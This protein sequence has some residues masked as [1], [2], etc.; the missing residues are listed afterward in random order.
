MRKILL[1]L[2][3]GLLFVLSSCSNE[4]K[5]V[6]YDNDYYNVEYSLN[7]KNLVLK[8]DYSISFIPIKK[9]KVIF[10]ISSI[11]YG[12]QAYIK[13]EHSLYE[14]P[15]YCL[16][17]YNYITQT[18]R[19]PPSLES[20][21][22]ELNFYVGGGTL[23]IEKITYMYEDDQ[24]IN[25]YYDNE[26]IFDSHL[27][28]SQMCPENTECAV[29]MAAKLGYDSCIVV[30]KETSDG[31]IVCIHDDTIN[32]TARDKNGNKLDCDL[33]VCELTLSNLLEYDFGI[34]K[35]K[36]WNNQKILTM[37][38]FLSLCKDYDISP[39][40]S[41]HPRLSNESWKYI[42]SLLIK[43]DLLQKTSIKAFDWTILKEAYDVFGNEISSYRGDNMPLTDLNKFL[44]SENINIDKKQI[45]IELEI[46]TLTK[47]KVDRYLDNGIR[48]YAFVLRSKTIPE[49]KIRDA[50][51]LGITG[52]V[53]DTYCQKGMLFLNF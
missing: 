8:D 53:D 12:N 35:N 45:I 39:I 44:N 32:R 25:N 43:Y 22:I 7:D 38:N 36:Y 11:N 30:P 29:I 15:K 18:W 17:N 31:E 14:S 19:V 37:D 52:F 49:T 24:T 51:A 5:F 28:F 41:T 34:Y 33:S 42:K 50:L 21:A 1:I 2:F 27:G 26:I 46:E 3:L 16:S 10:K 47:E 40:F 20:S 23:E 4:K 48:V 13:F 9:S 6:N